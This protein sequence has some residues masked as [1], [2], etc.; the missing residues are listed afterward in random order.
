MLGAQRIRLLLQKVDHPQ[1]I[2]RMDNRELQSIYGIGPKI[3]DEIVSFDKW[4]EVDRILRSTRE[5]G[6]ELMTFWDEDYPLL[7]R[8]IYDPPLL[9]WIRGYRGALRTDG[10]AI[11][12]TRKAGQYGRDA[13][14][15]FAEE[16]CRVGLT[17][18]SGLAYGI[19]GEAHRAAVEAGGCTVAVL[20]SGIDTIYPSGHK[21]LAADIVESGG[22]VISEFPLGTDPD[23]GNFPVRNRI[24]SGMTLG[25]LVAASGIA[26]GSMIT[27]KLA[28]DQNREVFVVPHPIGTPNA[29]GCNS[30]I[31]RGMGKLVQN[32]E[33]ILSE[34]DVHV[35]AGEESAASGGTPK[36]RS[37]DLDEPSAAICRVLEEGSLHIDVL[38]EK[39][40]VP[41]HKLLPTLLEL[42]MQECVCQRSGKKFELL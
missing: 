25:T 39:V 31:Q 42:E 9:L 12:G 7:L 1:D 41:P 35:S 17:V 27:A 20:G 2:F 40:G 4:D 30:L 13:A 8:E 6:A 26:G 11:V 32:V 34:I 5:T 37:V 15:H 21:K 18:V 22:A 28:L 3:A 16:L 19:D 24:V 23:A 36:W 29:M 38:A 33:D 14:R 10:V